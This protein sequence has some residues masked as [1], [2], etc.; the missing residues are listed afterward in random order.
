MIREKRREY[1]HCYSLLSSTW[2]TWS[3]NGLLADFS[4]LGFQPWLEWLKIILISQVKKDQSEIRLVVSDQFP[5]CC[6]SKSQNHSTLNAASRGETERLWGLMSMNPAAYP[7]HKHLNIDYNHPIQTG[8]KLNKWLRI[9]IQIKQEESLA[10]VYWNACT[11]I[12]IIK[13]LIIL[14]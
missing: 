4:P 12:T 14:D 5:Q 11:A 2:R 7:A 3:L 8:T 6:T 10:N 1:N 9:T 13:L